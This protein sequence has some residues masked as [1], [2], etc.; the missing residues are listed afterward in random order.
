MYYLLNILFFIIIIFIILINSGTPIQN[1]IDDLYGLIKF[2]NLE[3]FNK[4]S[5]WVNYI[6]K[7]M[8]SYDNIGITSLQTLMKSIAIRRTKDSKFNGKKLIELPPKSN[9]YVTLQLS[10][11]ARD[12][13]SRVLKQGKIIFNGLVNQGIWVSN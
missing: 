5:V 10:P 2:L 6:S 11:E 13:Y 9:E 8:K 7:P 1:K 12:V 3:P 4:K